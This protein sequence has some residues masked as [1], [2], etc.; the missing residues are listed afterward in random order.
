MAL[1]EGFNGIALTSMALVAV[2]SSTVMFL[3]VLMVIWYCVLFTALYPLYLMIPAFLLSAIYHI[4]VMSECSLNAKSIKDKLF[5]VFGAI[6]TM[7]S[8]I[9]YKR[10][11]GR[12]F[13]LRVVYFSLIYVLFLI[14]VL[15]DSAQIEFISLLAFVLFLIN[16]VW[17]RFADTQTTEFLLFITMLLDCLYGHGVYFGYAAMY[18]WFLFPF[19]YKTGVADKYG[20][21]EKLEPISLQSVT[22]RCENFMNIAPRESKLMMCFQDPHG[23]Y[24]NIFNGF[25]YSVE[26][27]VYSG[28]AVG[29]VVVPNYYMVFENNYIGARDTW[30]N[31]PGEVREKALEFGIDCVI[32]NTELHDFDRHAA[33]FGLVELGRYKELNDNIDSYSKK[34]Y[35]SFEWVMY[36]VV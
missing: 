8:D 3:L 4:C 1:F 11:K 14:S 17:K 19:L 25:R 6:G 20:C 28:Y 27:G 10:V 35:P 36:R 7:S 2:T 29:R 23:S 9:K 16:E 24:E 32:V 31:D 30:C 12:L 13:N 22:S 15:I 21:V 18:A 26:L 33:N 34:F 5:S